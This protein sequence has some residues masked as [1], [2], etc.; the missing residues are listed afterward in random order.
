[1]FPADI[2]ILCLYYFL[3]NAYCLYCFPIQTV[4]HTALPVPLTLLLPQPIPPL[5][6]LTLPLLLHTALLHLLTG[7]LL[8]S[9]LYYI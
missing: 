5:V 9:L 8:T 2:S 4:L 3:F 6:Q 7:N 1:M